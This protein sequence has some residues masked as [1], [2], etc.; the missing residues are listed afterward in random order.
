MSRAAGTAF[1]LALTSAAMFGSSGSFATSLLDAGWSTGA[2]VTVRVCLA[3]LLLLPLTL[4][5]LRGRSAQLRRAAGSTAAFGLIAVAG[6]QLAFFNAVAH[7][8]VAVALL[9]EYSGTLLVVAWLWFRR[10][11][12]PRR[13]TLGGSVL[14]LGGLALVLDLTGGGRVDAI[15]VGWAL[16]A[17]VG[18]A[19]Y[20]VVSSHDEDALPA[21][22]VAGVGLGI[23]AVVLVLSAV[24]GVLPFEAPR[25][26][27]E[28]LEQGVSWVVPVTGLGLVAGALAYASG[29]AG[30]R[31]LGA[32]VASFVGLTEVLFAV[33]LAWL[34]LGESL[35]AVQVLGGLL[36]VAGIAMV[37]VDEGRGP[38]QVDPPVP[39]LPAT[40]CVRR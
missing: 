31:R 10:G 39:E 13:M 5:A 16:L 25:G 7:L 29:I 12:R 3:A 37:R 33:A 32:K 28:L 24:S 35:A 38:G 6:C 20:F 8:S 18:L 21:V 4:L 26:D 36:V 2:A 14:S 9:L 22:A 15:G 19:V 34:L 17:A 1:G 11:H 27:V 40:G 23:G 30:A